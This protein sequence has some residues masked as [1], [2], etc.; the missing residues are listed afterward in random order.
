MK[1]SIIGLTLASIVTSGIARAEH[2]N[3]FA[4]VEGKWEVQSQDCHLDEGDS[5]LTTTCPTT[6]KSIDVKVSN[7]GETVW[8]GLDNNV[9]TLINSKGQTSEGEWDQ[10]FMTVGG[11]PDFDGDAVQWT[12][13]DLNKARHEQ[14]VFLVEFCPRTLVYQDVC[15]FARQPYPFQLFN[16]PTQLNISTGVSF[17]PQGGQPIHRSF[18]QSFSLR[19]V[20]R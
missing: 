13:M 7:D 10:G 3:F 4:I 15:A 5:S 2:Y 18:N 14:R 12:R 16:E 17:Y 11:G 20:V 8:L 6:H 1:L 9:M 19:R